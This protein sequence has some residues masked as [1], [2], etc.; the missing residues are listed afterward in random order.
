MML[1]LV[2]D[3]TFPPEPS[4]VTSPSRK[5]PRVEGTSGGRKLAFQLTPD[6][7]K[8]GDKLLRLI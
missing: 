8:G 6:A 3:A 7:V 1:V 5:N 2:G 4:T